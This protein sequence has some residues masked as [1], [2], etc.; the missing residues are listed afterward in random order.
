MGGAAFCGGK[1]ARTSNQPTSRIITRHHLRHQW[2][3]RVRALP[4]PI[5]LDPRRLP[6]S[7]A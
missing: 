7:R 1:A 3:L 4:N 5:L 6:L 2:A